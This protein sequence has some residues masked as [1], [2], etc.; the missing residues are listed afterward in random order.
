MRNQFPI[1]SHYAQSWT[2]KNKIYINYKIIHLN[3][4]VNVSH[5]VYT[6]D[7]SF[8]LLI[9]ALFELKAVFFN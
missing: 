6:Y 4:H 3:I 9:A 5:I 7:I 8:S 2:W 1:G